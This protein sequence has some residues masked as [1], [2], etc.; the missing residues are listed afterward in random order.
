MLQL[1]VPVVAKV[2]VTAVT[3]ASA[4]AVAAVVKVVAETVAKRLRN[5]KVRAV[6]EALP[7]LF[8]RGS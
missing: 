2:V 1:P 7:V 8:A 4:V 5:N 6:L 3:A